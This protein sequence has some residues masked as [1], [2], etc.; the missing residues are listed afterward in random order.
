[1]ESRSPHSVR[2]PRPCGWRCA[3]KSPTSW[4]RRCKSC[5]G[6]RGRRGLSTPRG[7]PEIMAVA[8]H[9]GVRGVKGAALPRLPR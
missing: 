7:G 3:M 2:R 1:M 4:A 6:A 8:L 9:D 5:P